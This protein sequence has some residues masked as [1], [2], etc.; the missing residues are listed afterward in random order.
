MFECVDD[1]RRGDKIALLLHADAH[2]LCI[3]VNGKRK[4]FA[5][6]NNCIG[7]IKGDFCSGVFFDS[8]LEDDRGSVPADED[9][10]VTVNMERKLPPVMT[11]AQNRIERKELQAMT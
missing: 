3:F 11:Q 2:N 5:N 7:E 4:G 8:N 1:P 6:S 10:R 9:C